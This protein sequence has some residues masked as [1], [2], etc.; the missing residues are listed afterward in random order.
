[1][2]SLVFELSSRGEVRVCLRGFLAFLPHIVPPSSPTIHSLSPS[3]SRAP[4]M[5]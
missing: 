1:M 2:Q 3:T 5:L 4:L